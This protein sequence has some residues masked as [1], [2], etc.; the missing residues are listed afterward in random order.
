MPLEFHWEVGTFPGDEG[1][2]FTPPVV[3]KEL[4]EFHRDF[5]NE[6]SD[7]REAMWNYYLPD[8]WVPHCTLAIN[9]PKDKISGAFEYV[10]ESFEPVKARIEEIGL[11]EFRPVKHLACYKLFDRK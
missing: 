1:V 11:V 2:I 5:N 8:L 10:L 6:F 9:V 4:L 7:C 3:T